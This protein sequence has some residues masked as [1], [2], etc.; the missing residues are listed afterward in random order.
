MGRPATADDVDA[1]CRALPEVEFG[2]SWGDRPTYKVPAGPKGR[3][4]VLYRGP[5]KDAIDPDTGQQFDDLIVIVVADEHAKAALVEDPGMP[6]FTID[7][8]RGYNAVL[9]Q[10]SRLAE[11]DVEELAE[12]ITDAWLARAPRSLA[13]TFLAA[14]PARGASES[15]PDG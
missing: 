2:T 3:G 8:F 4:F 6:F 10:E 15:R 5:R 13:K 14:R 12:I 9:V 1:I 7:H 11:L